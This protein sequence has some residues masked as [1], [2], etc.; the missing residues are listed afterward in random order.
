MLNPSLVVKNKFVYLFYDA[1]CCRFWFQDINLK[2]IKTNNEILAYY[3]MRSEE[4][5]TINNTDLRHVYTRKYCIIHYTHTAWHCR[6]SIHLTP[7][8]KYASREKLDSNWLERRFYLVQYIQIWLCQSMACMHLCK[9]EVVQIIP[10]IRC[11]L[12]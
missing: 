9:F 12:L 3:I 5:G 11:L 2:R 4:T 6:N 1:S 10:W 8:W 7:N